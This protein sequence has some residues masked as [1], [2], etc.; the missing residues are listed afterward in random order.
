MLSTLSS[1]YRLLG[2]ALPFILKGR[3]ILQDFCQEQLEWDDVIPKEYQQKWEDWRNILEGLEKYVY[4]D[5]RNNFRKIN[6]ISLQ[7]L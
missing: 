5:T 3:T 4:D 1:F 7:F 2:L 6:Y